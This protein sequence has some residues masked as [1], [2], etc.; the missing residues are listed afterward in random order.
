MPV[1]GCELNCAYVGGTPN[2]RLGTTAECA[3]LDG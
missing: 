2:A 3:A 1:G